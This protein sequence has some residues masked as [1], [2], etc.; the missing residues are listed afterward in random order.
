MMGQSASHLEPCSKPN[1]GLKLADDSVLMRSYVT[2]IVPTSSTSKMLTTLKQTLR[3]VKGAH[4]TK[5]GDIPVFSSG[6]VSAAIKIYQEKG[7]KFSIVF[8]LEPMM[9]AKQLKQG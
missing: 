9:N 7:G 2:N 8:A 3:K 1:C 4:V 5:A 6:D